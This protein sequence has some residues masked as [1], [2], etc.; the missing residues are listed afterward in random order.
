MMTVLGI[1]LLVVAIVVFGVIV[2]HPEVGLGFGLLFG[3]PGMFVTIAL[4]AAE[5]TWSWEAPDWAY[6]VFGG[7]FL[8]G[9]A[10][11]GLGTAFAARAND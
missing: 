9:F 6:T 10:L 11:I 5:Q 3:V 2:V 7:M 4:V 1:F 8:L